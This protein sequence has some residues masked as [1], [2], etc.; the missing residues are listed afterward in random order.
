MLLYLLK[1]VLKT[2]FIN[3]LLTNLLNNM[4]NRQN[5]IIADKRTGLI[6]KAPK[7]GA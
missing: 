4:G 6:K 2:Q 7:M 5:A 3:N 1:L